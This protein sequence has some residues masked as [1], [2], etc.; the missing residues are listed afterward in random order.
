M[1][2]PQTSGLCHTHL[3]SE[4]NK[5]LVEEDRTQIPEVTDTQVVYKGLSPMTEGDMYEEPSLRMFGYL[6][7]TTSKVEHEGIHSTSIWDTHHTQLYHHTFNLLP[8]VKTTQHR[9]QP[10]PPPQYPDLHLHYPEFLRTGHPA[11]AGHRLRTGHECVAGQPGQRG[12]GLHGGG[13]DRGC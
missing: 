11:Q 7:F 3:W 8:Q 6:G 13:G 10:G 4:L 5:K 12:V 1:T 9:R 2:R